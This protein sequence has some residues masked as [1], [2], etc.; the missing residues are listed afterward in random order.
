M[1]MLPTFTGTECLDDW[2][3][4]WG[5]IGEVSVTAYGRFGGRGPFMDLL[6]VASI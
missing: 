1:I 4:M 2:K 5:G 3:G 6:F